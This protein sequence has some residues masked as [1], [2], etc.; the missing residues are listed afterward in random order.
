MCNC[1]DDL[2]SKASTRGPTSSSTS[3]LWVGFLEVCGKDSLNESIVANL[4]RLK[5]LRVFTHHCW[6]LA[7]RWTWRL[8]E[9]VTRGKVGDATTRIIH[10]TILK[11]ILYN[12]PSINH[13]GRWP[14]STSLEW[15][16][17]TTQVNDDIATLC[18][19]KHPVLV[20][21]PHTFIEF[22]LRSVTDTHS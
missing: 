11:F 12:L 16:T 15:M 10:F 2:P 4:G 22:N 18:T 3:C 9:T 21:S 7:R 19:L 5:Q 20:N 1:Y 17:L 6:R 14:P 8:W 13:Q